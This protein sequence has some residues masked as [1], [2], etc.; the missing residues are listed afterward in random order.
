M[1]IHGLLHRRDRRG[2]FTVFENGESGKKDL[3]EQEILVAL[4]FLNQLLGYDLGGFGAENVEVC[5]VELEGC[6]TFE[7]ADTC[8]ETKDDAGAVFGATG[9]ACKEDNLTRYNL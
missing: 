4:E 9:F 2:F 8:E 5:V 1:E 3:L 7:P 6:L